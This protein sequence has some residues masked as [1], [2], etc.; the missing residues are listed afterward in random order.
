MDIKK[1]LDKQRSEDAFCDAI[2]KVKGEVTRAHRCVLGAASPY[3]YT[4]F[5]GEFKEKQEQ[6]IDLSAVFN[7]L[8]TLNSIIDFI[9]GDELVVK[10]DTVSELLR[11]AHFLMIAKITELCMKFLLETL[12]IDNCLWM[13]MLA[14]LY[15][16]DELKEICFD[17]ACT[18]FHDYLIN[19]QDALGLPFEYLKKYIQN[20]ITNHCTE[21]ELSSFLEKYFDNDSQ[22][23]NVNSIMETALKSKVDSSKPRKP[24]ISTKNN[25]NEEW[26][27]LPFHG[28]SIESDDE[29]LESLIKQEDKSVCET[30][31]DETE[32]L[33]FTVS[34]KC[35]LFSK[36]TLRW[37]EL[38]QLGNSSTN[39]N[40]KKV[41]AV[42]I[43]E[44][45]QFVLLT[46]RDSMTLMN[47]F[48]EKKYGVPVL[49]R[50]KQEATAG[51]VK[52]EQLLP[53]CSSSQL[54]CFYKSRLSYSHNVLK[55]TERRP[56]NINAFY[57]QRF[58]VE[59]WK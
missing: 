30:E 23:A 18:R 10:E 16:L 55:G 43:G 46:S 40:E 52:R 31:N 3:F 8:T 35:T 24:N 6:V 2:L 4:M 12:T 32:M 54:Y 1:K 39:R 7:S 58:D 17:L 38:L 15:S 29:E 20:G 42:G 48:T 28:A 34:D 9:Y 36:D 21:N 22:V 19:T 33:M 11:G 50:K 41:E 27:M 14:D 56:E 37:Y 49:P 47:I 5:Y 53:F 57:L 44:E 45:G 59:K 25:N 26:N 51:S 13:L